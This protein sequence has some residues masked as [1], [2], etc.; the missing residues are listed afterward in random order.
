[1]FNVI[2]RWGEDWKPDEGTT[3]SYDFATYAEV[4]AF[5]HGISEAEGWMGSDYQVTSSNGNITTNFDEE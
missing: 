4:E 3:T 1:M 2:V 5:L